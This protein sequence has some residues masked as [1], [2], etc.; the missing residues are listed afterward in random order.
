MGS[1]DAPCAGATMRIARFDI[2]C[3][4]HK[5]TVPSAKRRSIIPVL[6]VNREPSTTKRMVRGCSARSMSV[7]TDWRHVHLGYLALGSAYLTA[8]NPMVLALGSA[9]LTALNPMASP[10]VVPPRQLV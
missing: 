5:R 6:I 8:L 2:E 3:Q 7:L 9:Y 10:L 1:G 4:C